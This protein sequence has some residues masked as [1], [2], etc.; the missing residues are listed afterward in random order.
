M[1]TCHDHG[2]SIAAL[3]EGPETITAAIEAGFD[4]VQ[5]ASFIDDRCT[6]RLDAHPSTKIVF[7]VGV[8]L[9]PTVLYSLSTTNR[10]SLLGARPSRAYW[11]VRS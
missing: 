4:T 3:G 7:T 6:D 10:A 9:G 5:H 1:N 2:L 8:F 11:P